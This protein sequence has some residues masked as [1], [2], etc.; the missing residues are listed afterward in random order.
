M[1]REPL[2]IA[3]MGT[4]LDRLNAVFA[5]YGAEDLRQKVAGYYE[6]LR[7][8][9]AEQV[10]GAVTLAIK[11]ELRFPPPAK[12]HEHARTWRQANRPQLVE[13]RRAADPADP[14]GPICSCGAVPRL[15]W[16][17]GTDWKTGETFH[18][19]RYIAPCDPSRHGAGGYVPYPPTFLTWAE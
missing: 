2:T 9:D 11:S 5:K 15:A 14:N 13:Q 3:V 6:A 17:E 18:V 16:I 4:E 8:L 10:K 19:K 1:M 7:E 12:I